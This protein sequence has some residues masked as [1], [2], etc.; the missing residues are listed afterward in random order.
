MLRIPVPD[1]YILAACLSLRFLRRW[2]KLA[3]KHAVCLGFSGRIA[4]GLRGCTLQ[5]QIQPCRPPCKITS[6]LV[7]PT[8]GLQPK[9]S[10]I[11]KRFWNLLLYEKH[12]K[13]QLR[14]YDRRCFRSLHGLSTRSSVVATALSQD[15]MTKPQAYREICA[16]FEI[17]HCVTAAG[18]YGCYG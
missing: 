16:R 6:P 17:R 1:C 14:S 12:P 10:Y 13:D 15:C 11:T 4:S 2:A 18:S 3:A 7:K 5:L 9:R 8:H